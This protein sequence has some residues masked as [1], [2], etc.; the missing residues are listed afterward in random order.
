MKKI[1]SLILVAMCGLGSSF[2]YADNRAGA[3]TIT[4][5]VGLY[6][7][8]EKRHVHDAAIP[9]LALAYNFTNQWGIEASFGTFNSGYSP[10][11]VNGH[12]K[13][14]LYLVD[15][16]YYYSAYKM[17]TPY[18]SFGTGILYLNTESNLP[19]IL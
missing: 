10:A 19:V 17:L 15:G 16:M 5:G 2:T 18:L 11:S 13:A 9:N 12:A 1:T 4:P 7:F 3:I 6:S 8:S 14:R